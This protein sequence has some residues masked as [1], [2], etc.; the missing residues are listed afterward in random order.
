MDRLNLML[1]KGQYKALEP[2]F[3]A[4]SDSFDEGKAGG[5]IAQVW[6]DEK[7]GEGCLQIRVLDHDMMGKLQAGMGVEVGTIPEGCELDA[8]VAEEP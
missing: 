2:M 4:V 3:K 8:I 1:M 6:G 7:R 5:I